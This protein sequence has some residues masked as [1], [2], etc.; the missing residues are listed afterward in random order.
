VILRRETG[1]T[2]SQAQ[3]VTQGQ[4]V[5]EGIADSGAQAAQI[6]PG[7]ADWTAESSGHS[8]PANEHDV[9]IRSHLD[10]P[11]SRRFNFVAKKECD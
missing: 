3:H 9:T 7:L 5:V 11:I 6:N 2:P 10:S 4:K 1:R 8:P